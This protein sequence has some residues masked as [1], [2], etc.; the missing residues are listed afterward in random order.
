MNTF[1]FVLSLVLLV[2][3]LPIWIVFNYLG[4]VRST[5]MLSREDE[6][7][8]GELWQ[9]ARKMENRIVTL[10]TILDADNPSWRKR[11]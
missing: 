4:K 11:R 1:T 5:R 7:M 2:V 6:A 10:E 3:V 9:L 8:L